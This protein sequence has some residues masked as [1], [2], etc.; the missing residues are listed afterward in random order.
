LDLEP[1]AQ[2]LSDES[3][4]D[5]VLRT[6][7]EA[8]DL[9]APLF[10]GH[11]TGVARLSG[12]IA[13]RL[14]FTE[15]QTSEVVRAAHV[16]DLGR[17]AIPSSVWESASDLSRES[18]SQVHL[19]A[20]HSEQ[21]LMRSRPLERVARL[22]GLHHERLDGSGYHRGAPKSQLPMAAR[23]LATADVYQALISERPYR[24]ALTPER[25]S[26]ELTAMSRAGA[27][28]PDAVGALLATVDPSRRPKLPASHGLTDRQVEVLR[29]VASGL[30]NR[31]IGARLAISPRTAERHVQ[32]VYARIGVASRA[33]SALFAMEH[34]LLAGD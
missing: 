27:L 13:T 12:Q 3:A 16:H 8:V 23:V 20:Y 18:W 28:D 21:I 19:H 33:A 15:A 10:H 26:R 25:A 6:F 7:G 11:S 34:G 2:Y 5:H 14:R 4:I 31:D 29:L 30:S 17:A 22:A 9:K 32:D 24:A 1:H